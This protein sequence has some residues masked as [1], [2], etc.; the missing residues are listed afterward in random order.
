[1]A[2]AKKIAPQAKN[3]FIGFQKGSIA[4]FAKKSM[5]IKRSENLF[6]Q[7]KKCVFYISR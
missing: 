4:D 2:Q 5:P 6:L 1:M 7:H 3:S